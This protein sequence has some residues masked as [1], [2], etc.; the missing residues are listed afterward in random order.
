MTK[1]TV[2]AEF[3][4]APVRLPSN[5]QSTPVYAQTNCENGVKIKQM[6]NKNQIELWQKQDFGSAAQKVSWRRSDSRLVVMNA[7]NGY[8]LQEALDNGGGSAG[9]ETGN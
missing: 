8:P 3:Q 1:G 7:E 2:R 4:G 6:S 9:F 5:S